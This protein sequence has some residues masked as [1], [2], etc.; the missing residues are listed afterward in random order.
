MGKG[1]EWTSQK[2]R[3]ERAICMKVFLSTSNGRNANIRNDN[4]YTHEINQLKL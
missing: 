1:W 4:M 3:Y 2:R